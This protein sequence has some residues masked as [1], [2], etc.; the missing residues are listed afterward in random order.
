MADDK[1]IYTFLDKGTI[2]GIPARDLTQ[3]DFDRLSLERQRDVRAGTLYRAV[4]KAAQADTKRI[5]KAA[6]AAKDG[7]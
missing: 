6:D 1:A 5:Q 4:T 7:E 3:K 2:H